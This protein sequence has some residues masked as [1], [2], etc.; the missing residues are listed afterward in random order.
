MSLRPAEPDRGAH[1]ADVSQLATSSRG[2]L[3]GQMRM[4]PLRNKR[5]GPRQ[6]VDRTARFVMQTKLYGL[7]Q[8]QDRTARL[9]CRPNSTALGRTGQNSSIRY[10]DEALRSSAKTGEDSSIRYA[11][12][13]LRS[14]A[15]TGED[16][17]IRYA[18]EAL[19][20]SAKTGEDSSTAMLT[21]LY[22]PRQELNRT[23][24]RT[25]I[26][27]RER[28]N[29]VHAVTKQHSLQGIL[30]SVWT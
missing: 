8:K 23:A 11:D 7:L 9:P 29:D 24:H 25:V 30:N 10:A 17:S 15:K 18:D 12:E 13:A 1:P 6:E 19:R 2:R 5:Y 3:T 4:T 26:V 20:S 22:C 16:S 28:K 21:R 14:S 27:I